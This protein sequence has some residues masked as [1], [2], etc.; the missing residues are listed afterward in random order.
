MLPARRWQAMKFSISVFD[1]YNE[2][3][4]DQSH[5]HDNEVLNELEAMCAVKIM[6]AT[7]SFIYE[8]ENL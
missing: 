7:I 4:N 5:A 8:F 2:T 1:K 6:A 3:R